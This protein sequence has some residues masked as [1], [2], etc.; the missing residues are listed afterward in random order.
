MKKLYR[1]SYFF[2]AKPWILAIFMGKSMQYSTSVVWLEVFLFS[3]QKIAIQ[4]LY[5][6]IFKYFLAFLEEKTH[7]LFYLSFDVKDLFFFC[8]REGGKTTD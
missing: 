6:T 1:K 8:G 2:I 4:E 5:E 7:R 3:P